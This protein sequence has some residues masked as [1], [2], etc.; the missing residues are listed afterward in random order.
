[1]DNFGILISSL[2]LIFITLIFITGFSNKNML[3]KIIKDLLYIKNIIKDQQTII[4][5]KDLK[6]Y[7]ED[8]CFQTKFNS[9]FKEE[10][11]D[12]K[13]FK[14]TWK[15]NYNSFL[16]Y[17]II[18][19]KTGEIHLKI[20]GNLPEISRCNKSNYFGFSLDLKFKNGRLIDVLLNDS[21]IEGE[22]SVNARVLISKMGNGYIQKV[23]Y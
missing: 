2:L 4:E 10:L 6:N 17:S 5:N 14:W 21:I 1:M 11:K 7:L 19:S 9:S 16:V 13:P 15:P 8:N 12:N 23:L 18:E 3:S 20:N 22:T